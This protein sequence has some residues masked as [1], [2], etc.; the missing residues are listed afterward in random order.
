MEIKTGKEM[1]QKFSAKRDVHTD[2]ICWGH[3]QIITGEGTDF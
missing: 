1:T 2:T 3:R